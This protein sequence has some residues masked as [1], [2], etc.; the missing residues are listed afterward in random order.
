[1]RRFFFVCSSL[2]AVCLLSLA[3]R[4]NAGD[5][6][7]FLRVGPGSTGYVNHSGSGNVNSTVYAEAVHGGQVVV[8]SQNQ[9]W[10][11][12][13]VMNRQS[14]KSIG[15]SVQMRSNLNSQGGVINNDQIAA[16]CFGHIQTNTA[17]NAIGPGAVLNMRTTDIVDRGSI[18]TNVIGNTYAA[19]G[20]QAFNNIETVTDVVGGVGVNQVQSDV[21][22]H[23]GFARGDVGSILPVGPYYPVPMVNRVNSSVESFGGYAHGRTYYINR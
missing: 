19:P 17:G 5:I 15:G 8:D 2:T 11:G 13:A 18:H 16:S 14:A 20:S 6:N 1:M 3:P 7:S 9:A 23:Q 22:A 4:L 21:Y 12:G 10:G